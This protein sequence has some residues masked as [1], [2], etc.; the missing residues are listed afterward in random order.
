VDWGILT[1]IVVGAVVGWALHSEKVMPVPPREATPLSEFALKDFGEL[2]HRQRAELR[3]MVR[4]ISQC[5]ERM[6]E[7]ARELHKNHTGYASESGITDPPCTALERSI[8][9]LSFGLQ[10]IAVGVKLSDEV[11]RTVAMEIEPVARLEARSVHPTVD[12][13]PASGLYRLTIDVK[14]S[15]GSAARKTTL[16]VDLD[17]MAIG[18][19]AELDRVGRN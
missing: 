7:L 2:S 15:D 13:E 14:A 17:S 9:D 11:D 3:S 18:L 6:R 8:S 10:R 19:L 1:G 16:G 5:H 12:F 4:E